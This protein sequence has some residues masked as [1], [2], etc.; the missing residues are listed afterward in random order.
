MSVRDRWVLSSSRARASPSSTRDLCF[1]VQ[2]LAAVCISLV[3]PGSLDPYPY[4]GVCDETQARTQVASF[5]SLSAV[6]QCIPRW[7]AGCGERWK[8]RARARVASRSSCA[9]EVATVGEIRLARAV[10]GA[11]ASAVEASAL[12]ALSRSVPMTNPGSLGPGASGGVPS[13]DKGS[14]CVAG[15]IDHLRGRNESPGFGG[16]HTT[17]FLP[18]AGSAILDPAITCIQTH[19]PWRFS[20][21][22]SMLCSV[23]VVQHEMIRALRAV[24]ERFWTTPGRVWERTTRE[25]WSWGSKRKLGEGVDCREGSWEGGEDGHRPDQGEM[26]PPPPPVP[27]EKK[28][29]V[30]LDPVSLRAT[31]AG[32][33]GDGDPDDPPDLASALHCEA[34]TARDSTS[35]SVRM[36]TEQDRLPLFSGDSG[37]FEA[38]DEVLM[39]ALEALHFFESADSPT[40]EVSSRDGVPDLGKRDHGVP[41]DGTCRR[42]GTSGARESSQ[43]DRHAVL[44]RHT[45]SI[46]CA[47]RM[48]SPFVETAR[49][50]D[51]ERNEGETSHHGKRAYGVT[52]GSCF[53]TGNYCSPSRAF[54][55]AFAR[56][57]DGFIMAV[58]EATKHEFGEDHCGDGR[59]ASSI[60][61]DSPT[62]SFPRTIAW[63]RD[64]LVTCACALPLEVLV[65]RPQRS[66]LGGSSGEDACHATRDRIQT[67]LPAAI[68]SAAKKSLDLILA[69]AGASIL[70]A[71]LEVGYISTSQDPGGALVPDATVGIHGAA[72]GAIS[73]HGRSARTTSLWVSGLLDGCPGSRGRSSASVA[74]LTILGPVAPRAPFPLRCFLL[75]AMTTRG[76]LHGSLR[77]T[78]RNLAAR[79]GD[80]Q[81]HA[82]EDA[83]I[84][85]G[86]ARSE[87][88]TPGSGGV[89]IDFKDSSDVV[90][91]KSALSDIHDIY[92]AGLSHVLPLVRQSAVAA[93]PVLDLSEDGAHADG[94]DGKLG[95]T[96]GAPRD[97]FSCSLDES[98]KRRWLPALVAT[99]KDG[100]EAVRLELAASLPRLGASLYR[101]RRRKIAGT[102]PSLHLSASFTPWT[103]VGHHVDRLGHD[104][105]DAEAVGPCAFNDLLA[106]WQPLLEDD[107]AVVRAAAA[108]AGLLCASASPLSRLRVAGAP[109]RR[110][111]GCLVEMLACGDPEVAMVFANGAGHF[112]ANDGKILRAL[113]GGG[114]SRGN[115]GNH[116][117]DRGNADGAGANEETEGEDDDDEEETMGEEEERQ[118]GVRMRERALSRFIEAVGALL[119]EHGEKVRLGRWQS[120]PEFTALLR[121]VG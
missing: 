42:P 15:D 62:A 117:E 90:G 24:L 21:A 33:D 36:S 9:S 100:D 118:K 34:S 96:T 3:F 115:D 16:R 83:P 120:L 6:L 2:E 47:L 46:T 105:D 106:L 52:H 112:V 30:S 56:L 58:R 11:F 59:K 85:E 53:H 26:A 80:L 72:G 69:P 27:P 74:R 25:G 14:G 40:E 20:E 57:G 82:S 35:G 29:K 64:M 121:A 8:G 111:L 38:V 79:Q 60:A 5:A 70:R 71:A 119:R 51:D 37:V 31:A 98:W 81:G 110:I 23:P 92:L 61:S 66:E 93:L 87:K 50:P 12:K 39:R 4:L 22:M 68:R 114:A 75:L 73:G 41:S 102:K 104:I 1:T 55:L 86:G 28:R 76:D 32:R 84:A 101:G 63:T 48:L 116:A 108:R 54:P 43:E 88:G 10:A 67:S 44:L 89:H 18:P 99:T 19:T 103:D 95:P 94:E 107:S 17:R 7:W 65:T 113:Y 97:G 91:D 49:V 109:G 78:S 77:A 13:A 45:A